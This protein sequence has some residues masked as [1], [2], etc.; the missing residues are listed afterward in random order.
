LEDEALAWKILREGK[1]TP[2]TYLSAKDVEDACQAGQIFACRAHQSYRTNTILMFAIAALQIFS[3]VVYGNIWDGS[4]NFYSGEEVWALLAFSMLSVLCAAVGI[5]TWATYRKK[6]LLIGP[7]GILMCYLAGKSLIPWQ[8]VLNI[9]REQDT[10]HPVSYSPAILID[11]IGGLL[12]VKISNAEYRPID[13]L[14][15]SGIDGL[16][17]VLITYFK[18]MRTKSV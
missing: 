5:F 9:N 2:K 18:K 4:V 13:N 11:T 17:Y 12:N 14:P 15:K 7:V 3:A 6:I 8:A 1:L 16:F 10:H